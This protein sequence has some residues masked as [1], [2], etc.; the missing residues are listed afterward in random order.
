M[1]KTRQKAGISTYE[2]VPLVRKPL[3]SQLHKIKV[4]PLMAHGLFY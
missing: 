4:E 1:V 3:F 2:K